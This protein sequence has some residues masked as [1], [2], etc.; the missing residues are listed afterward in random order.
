MGINEKGTIYLVKLCNR[1]RLYQKLLELDF[2]LCD[3]VFIVKA[4][5]NCV[6]STG[7]SIL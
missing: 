7:P 4:M 5:F 3:Y 2:T 6:T 1:S